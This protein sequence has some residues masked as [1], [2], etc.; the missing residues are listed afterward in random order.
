MS[1]TAPKKKKEEKMK[2]QVP[3][4]LMRSSKAAERAGD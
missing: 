3:E 2:P 1:P 4:M